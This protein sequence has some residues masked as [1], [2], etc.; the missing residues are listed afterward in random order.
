MLGPEREFVDA[1]WQLHEREAVETRRRTLRLRV[2]A[3]AAS[4]LAAVP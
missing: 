3:T 1:A 2:L 4:I